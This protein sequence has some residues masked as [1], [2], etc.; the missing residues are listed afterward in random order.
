MFSTGR[1]WHFGTASTP[2][3]NTINGR[4]NC[5]HYS[6]INTNALS[7]FKLHLKLVALMWEEHFK[8]HVFFLNSQLIR[9]KLLQWMSASSLHCRTGQ[10]KQ[11][12]RGRVGGKRWEELTKR[13]CFPFFPFK[14]SDLGKGTG[15][16]LYEYE[17]RHVQHFYGKIST[18]QEQI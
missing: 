15:D 13:Q 18:N 17:S 5:A 1:V 6:R 12:G 11:R 4:T 14:V 16:S 9:A 7:H 10:Q 8:D 3:S 2:P